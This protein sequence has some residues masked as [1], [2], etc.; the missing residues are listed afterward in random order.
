MRDL[1]HRDQRLEAERRVAH[2]AALAD[3]SP[4][5]LE[6][7][8]D[9]REAVES[10]GGTP[11]HRGQHLRQGDERDVDHDQVGRVGQPAGRQRPRVRSLD[12]RDPPVGS[13]PP[14]E[15]AVGNVERDHVRGSALEQA[16]REP[17]RA[18]TDVESPAAPHVQREP[19]QGVG[20][21]DPAA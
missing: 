3:R 4:S 20:Q 18:G 8:F 7:R 17:A 21:L 6:L 2:D 13:Q 12:H 16:V 14:V 1:S 19:I 5:H 10:V 9:E 15:L 11:Q